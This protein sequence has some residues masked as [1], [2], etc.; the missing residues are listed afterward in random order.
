[1]TTSEKLGMMINAISNDTLKSQFFREQMSEIAINNLTEFRS[2][3]EPYK[4][5]T[6]SEA[7]KRNTRQYTNRSLATLP[8]LENLLTIFFA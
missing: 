3:F 2:T 1:L 4:K 8:M 6:K 5:Y 7:A